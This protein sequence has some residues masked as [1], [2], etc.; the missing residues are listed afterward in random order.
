[1]W[2]GQRQICNMLPGKN[3]ICGYWLAVEN[4]GEGTGMGAGTLGDAEGVAVWW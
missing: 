4:G 1:M 3:S 2:R